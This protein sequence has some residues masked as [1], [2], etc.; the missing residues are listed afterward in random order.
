MPCKIFC[1]NI[2]VMLF[3]SSS[4]FSLSLNCCWTLSVPKLNH[5]SQVFDHSLV[6]NDHCMH[7]NAQ[8]TLAALE[9]DWLTSFCGGSKSSLDKQDNALGLLVSGNSPPAVL[10][11]NTFSFVNSLQINHILHPG[12]RNI[13]RPFIYQTVSHQR[14][15][16]SLLTFFSKHFFRSTF[17]ATAKETDV[18]K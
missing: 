1:I 6:H 9:E 5:F 15:V 17:L 2:E 7:C 3:Q 14:D 18:L 13:S 8:I 16:I 10:L 4:L 11:S 12:N